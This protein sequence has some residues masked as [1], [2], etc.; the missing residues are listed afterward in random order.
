MNIEVET[1]RILE[2]E[3]ELLVL[4][5]FEDE[6]VEGLAEQIDKVLN[7]EITKIL[8][9]K[10][11]EGK[12]KQTSLLHTHGRIGIRRILLVGLGKREEFNLEVARIASGKAAQITRELGVKSYATTIIGDYERLSLSRVVESIVEGCELALYQFDRYKT[13]DEEGKK[14]IDEL[15]VFAES[16]ESIGEVERSISTAQIIDRGVSLAR[17]IANTPSSDATPSNI[18]EE[19]KKISKEN[20]IKCTI[21]EAKDIE[22]LGMG[23]II[24]VARGSQQPPRLVIMEYKGEEEARPI[25]L[26]GKGITFDSGGISIKQSLKMEE[27]KYDKSGAATVIA[28]MQTVAQLQLPL[29]IIGITPLTENLPSGSAYKPGDILRIY[30]KKTVEVISTDAEGRLIMADA[31]AYASKYKPQATIDLATLTGACVI[32]LGGV[33]TGLLSNN[34]DLKRRVKEAGEV[35][36]ERV[37]ELPLWKE[38]EEQ[39]KSEVADMKNVG[40]RPAGVITAALFLSN[41]V[42]YPWV[43]LDIAGTAWTQEGSPE[44]SYIPKGATGVGVRLII[45]VLRSWKT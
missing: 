37:W 34:D 7:Q 31:L 8:K 33:A 23:G 21:L 5:I 44:K 41:F 42:D 19:A 40:G 15:I 43:H 32:A 10:E 4:G 26:V 30:N 1:G 14:E 11:F 25:V 28:V 17:D 16:L 39:L 45:E 27:M 12:P 35:T 18:A 24:N 38:Y 9:A 13:K 2:K 29:N 22:K 6:E 3:Y 36:G 20:R